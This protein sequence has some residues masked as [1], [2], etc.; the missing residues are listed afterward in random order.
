MPKYKEKSVTCPVEHTLSII[1]NKWAVL[2]IRD[3]LDGKKRFGVLSRSLSGISPRTLSL[4]LAELNSQG[5]VKKRVFY[6]KPPLKVEY[7]LT[8]KGRELEPILDQMRA[9]GTKHDK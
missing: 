2:V 8:A 3:L 6:E 7:S 5:I 4:R 9:W 1:G